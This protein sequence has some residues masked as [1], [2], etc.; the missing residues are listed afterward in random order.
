MLNKSK[1]AVFC[2]FAAVIGLAAAAAADT[3]ELK[4]G[5]IINGAYMGGT[6]NSVRFSV[7]GEIQTV[8]VGD[9]LALTF[10]GQQISALEP[11]EAPPTVEPVHASAPPAPAILAPAGSTLLVRVLDSI[12]SRQ[13]RVGH[14][15]AAALEADFTHNGHVIAPRG[16]QVYGVIVD[17]KQ[18]GRIKGKTHLTLELQDLMINGAL[19]P[20]V[21]GEYELAG[22][23]SSGKRTALTT[24]GGAALG[25]LI[26]G[27]GDRAEGAAI[28]AGAGLGV[29]A[30]TKGEQ[31][32]IPTGTLI[33][34]R[35]AAPFS[36]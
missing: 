6:Q 28:G 30:I 29:S 19:H 15:F 25:A 1:F 22:N 4:N 5:D 8:P 10:S 2:T 14:R 3:L 13:H 24:I 33:Q 31:I 34:F 16:S 12:D 23:K 27:K 35:L 9:I 18:A 21:T 36:T 7:D 20:L 11:V 17:A 26:G 32:Q